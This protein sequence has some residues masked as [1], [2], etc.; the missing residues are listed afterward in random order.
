VKIRK[1]VII[2]LTPLIAI[3]L[4]ISNVISGNKVA[5][6]LSLAVWF[7]GAILGIWIGRVFKNYRLK[8]ALE[9]E[10]DYAINDLSRIG[11]ID[12]RDPEKLYF[13]S[14]NMTRFCQR[15][16]RILTDRFNYDLGLF[17]ITDPSLPYSF[18]NWYTRR[19]PGPRLPQSVLNAIKLITLKGREKVVIAGEQEIAK[20]F[21]EYGADLAEINLSYKRMAIIPVARNEKEILGYFALAGDRRRTMLQD[22]TLVGYPESMLLADIEDMKIADSLKFFIERQRLLLAAGLVRILNI[23]VLEKIITREIN[24]LQDCGRRIV[25]IL[26]EML[27]LPVGFIYLRSDILET[28]HSD[29]NPYIFVRAGKSEIKKEIEQEFL[30]P[31]INDWQDAWPKQA[32]K[33]RILQVVRPKTFDL[34]YFMTC[35]IVF[36]ST[37]SGMLGLM[38]KREFNDFDLEL[39]QIIQNFIIREC[40]RHLSGFRA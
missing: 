10:I 28:G 9:S 6:F 22:L 16:L 38:A 3:G 29:E 26:T 36:E 5:F 20:L 32:I 12:L 27:N 17:E 18:F 15:F 33:E 35:P 8:E 13:E 21:K 4:L 39:L 30:V 24:D 40:F 19:G 23:K 34:D 7:I 2:I 11:K 25:K 31:F 37:H 1:N 14:E